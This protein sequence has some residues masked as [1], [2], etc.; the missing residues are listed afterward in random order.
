MNDELKA[1]SFQFIVHRSSFIVLP[2]SFL[3]HRFYFAVLKSEPLPA[4]SN[5]CM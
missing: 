2:S 3:L 4:G 1:T 5:C